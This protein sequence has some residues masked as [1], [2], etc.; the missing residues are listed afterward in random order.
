MLFF[1]VILFSVV[2]LFAWVSENAGLVG[3]LCIAVCVIVLCV[4]PVL[5]MVYRK[6]IRL[7]LIYCAVQLPVLSIRAF[8]RAFRRIEEITRP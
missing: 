3:A 2:A 7:A 8:R 6:R 1:F 4:C 5:L